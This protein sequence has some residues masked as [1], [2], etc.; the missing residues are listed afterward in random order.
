MITLY[1]CGPILG[2]SDAESKDWREEIKKDFYFKDFKIL[3]P[4]RRDYRGKEQESFRE[5]VE[6]D[7]IDVAQSDILIVN[8]PQPSAGTSM[9]VFHAFRTGKFVVTVTP[10]GAK[11]SPWMQYHSHHTVTSFKDA[12]QIIFKHLLGLGY[13]PDLRSF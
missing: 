3:D 4:M 1:L 9:E 11:L 12:K 10:E 8:A 7:L 13:A 6:L 2:C 5:I